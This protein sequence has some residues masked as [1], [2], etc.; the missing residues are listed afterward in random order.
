M[1]KG[2]ILYKDNYEPIKSLTLEE[3]GELLEAIFRY[4]ISGEIIGLS[5]VAK[6]AFQ[7][8]K[9]TFDRDIE[10][11]TH[12]CERNHENGLKG[13]RPKKPSISQI[14]QSVNYEPKK[15]HIDI[16]IDSH[17]DKDNHNHTITSSGF[18]FYQQN[19]NPNI[20]SYEAELVKSLIDKYSEDWF[21]QACKVAVSNNARK[22]KYIEAVLNKSKDNGFVSQGNKEQ[23][24][25]E[26]RKIARANAD[27]HEKKLKEEGLL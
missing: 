3:K 24:E 23:S 11:Y 17:K 25:A 10:K 5:P 6:M 22:I 27:A 14:T 18:I 12:V 16:D 2:F 1:K 26:R 20:T 15:A 19:I 8:L 4:N 7:F 13:G 21:I 9:P